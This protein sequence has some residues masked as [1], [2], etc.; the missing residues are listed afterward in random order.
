[1]IIWVAELSAKAV[2]KN[3]VYIVTE[4]ENI[5]ETAEKYGYKA[6]MT[7][8]TAL[9]GTDRIAEACESLSYDIFVNVQ[10]D[11]PLVNPKEITRCINLKEANPDC[12]INGFCRIS[13]DEDPFS[14]NIPKVICNE[15]SELIYM[16]RSP[17]PSYKDEGNKPAYYL[18]QVC[19][20][21]F[22]KEELRSFRNFGQKSYLEKHEDIE[23]LRFLEMNKKIIMYET[24]SDSMAVDIPEDVARVEAALRKRMN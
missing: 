12:V 8:K 15:K 24:P 21:G 18:K 19:I 11:E 4:S 16:S 9:T 1:M 6:V 22:S 3:N 14:R 17:L 23:I 10:G 2:G 7:S 20:Y 13:A 5:Y